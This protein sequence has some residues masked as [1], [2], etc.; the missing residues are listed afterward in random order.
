MKIVTVPVFPPIPTRNFDWQAYMDGTIDV[1]GDPEC[2]CRSKA[3][4]GM[5]A[6]EEEAIDDLLEQLGVTI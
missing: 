1:C 2:G 5:G 3:I 4:V 6:T